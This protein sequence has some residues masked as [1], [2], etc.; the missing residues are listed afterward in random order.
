MLSSSCSNWWCFNWIR[1]IQL[2]A[3]LDT[4]GRLSSNS[5]AS[6]IS[7]ESIWLF[8]D[9]TWQWYTPGR[10]GNAHQTLAGGQRH[11]QEYVLIWI[12]DCQQPKSFSL[13]LQSSLARQ[14]VLRFIKQILETFRF[15]TKLLGWQKVSVAIVASL[16]SLEPETPL[17]AAS[18]LVIAWRVKT[19][20]K[21]R[22]NC[23]NTFICP[24][25]LEAALPKKSQVI[26]II[27]TSC[28]CCTL[29][30]Q[31]IGFLEW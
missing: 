30:H 9:K 8:L 31:R 7:H 26:R 2:A 19:R 27:Y 13:D 21:A 11:K 17:V 3:W 10:G 16:N 5:S 22:K 18:P 1:L 20:N 4:V 15:A 25:L 28:R 12:R 6:H 14:N 29:T 24:I 23:R